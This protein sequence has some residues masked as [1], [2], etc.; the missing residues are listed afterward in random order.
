MRTPEQQAI[1][2]INYANRL[3]DGIGD[4]PPANA[5]AVL[6]A[7]LDKAG[8]RLANAKDD[9][10][11]IALGYLRDER[12]E[13][14]KKMLVDAITPFI[15]AFGKITDVGVAV[16]KSRCDDPEC[17]ACKALEDVMTEIEIDQVTDAVSHGHTLD[18]TCPVC[19]DDTQ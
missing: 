1:R 8:L 9:R 18:E 4:D 17:E 16:L 12:M 15:E 14:A 2:Q 13:K 5:A 7:G 11:K 19:N 10:V 3:V 6:I